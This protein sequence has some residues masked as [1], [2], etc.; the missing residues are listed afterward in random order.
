MKNDIKITDLAAGLLTA[1][2]F[3]IVVVTLIVITSGCGKNE[4]KSNDAGIADEP[5]SEE[6]PADEDQAPAKT[7]AT[8]EAPAVVENPTPV[9]VEPPVIVPGPVSEDP[10]IAE[11]IEEMDTL[12]QDRV[13][14]LMSWN[15]WD[16]YRNKPLVNESP[17]RQTVANY[18]Q[19][20]DSHPFMKVGGVFGQ[21]AT[22][23]DDYEGRWFGSKVDHCGELVDS[24]ES[25]LTVYY[26]GREQS[27][28]SKI[29]IQMYFYTPVNNGPIY[30]TKI[31]LTWKFSSGIEQESVREARCQ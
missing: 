6:T 18:F 30:I 25:R 4:T 13:N 8:Y 2:V 20:H 9:T 10:I 24:K 23:M 27:E 7:E 17:S 14:L 31:K 11:K 26:I 15:I 29:N 5:V 19:L 16:D 22:F 1:L 28:H 21:E 3:Q 12:I